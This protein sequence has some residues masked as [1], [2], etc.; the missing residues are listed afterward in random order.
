MQDSSSGSTFEI[1]ARSLSAKV[2]VTHAGQLAGKSLNP[3]KTT[4]KQKV[5]PVTSRPRKTS[6]SNA[7]GKA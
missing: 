2:K 3:N 1:H 5:G 6:S 4:T 7:A